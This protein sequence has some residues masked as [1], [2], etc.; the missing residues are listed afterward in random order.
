MSKPRTAVGNLARAIC[1]KFPDAGSLTLAKML[2]KQNPECFHTVEAARQ[3]VRYFRC[4]LGKKNRAIILAAGTQVPRLQLPEAEPT[5]YEVIEIDDSIK[6]WLIIG[7]T[8]VPFQDNT[9]LTL[10]SAYAYRQNCD[11]LLIL[12][13]FLDC[14]MLSRWI[15]DPRVRRFA[16]ELANAAAILEELITKNKFK[17][18]IWKHGNHEL[19]L[20]KYLAQ[21][22]PDIFELPCMSDLKAMLFATGKIRQE[23]LDKITIYPTPKMLRHHKLYILHGHELGSGISSPVNPA[24]G[25]Y[26][27]A[28]ECC[29][30][31]HQH[32]PSEHTDPTIGNRIVTTWS[33]GCTCKIH[34]DYK[35]VNRWGHGFAVLE[36]GSEWEIRNKRIVNGTVK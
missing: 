9:T 4:A 8:H 17:T 6:R 1:V 15:K 11:G 23:T 35:L 31:A 20:E 27:K 22:A 32:Q 19:R 13:D 28:K 24:R 2:R 14:Y 16:A 21:H 34:P 36:S 26:L 3:A 30:V 25:A 29:I 12:G 18:C 7:D 10:A 5:Q 33:I